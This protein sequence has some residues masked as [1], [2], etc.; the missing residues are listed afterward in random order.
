VPNFRHF[1]GRI[2]RR[3]IALIRRLQQRRRVAAHEQAYRSADALQQ[4][5]TRSPETKL[6]VVLH[7]YYPQMWDYFRTNMTHIA[8]EPFDLYITLPVSE[9]EWRDRLRAQVPGVRIIMV[10]NRGRDILPFIKLAPL[11]SNLGYDYCLKLHTKK[12]LHWDGG[13]E[14]LSEV[15]VSLLPQQ[16]QLMDEII[17]TIKTSAAVIGPRNHYFA[18]PV[19]YPANRGHLMAEISRIVSES[20]AT[21]LDAQPGE[22]GFFGGSMLWLRI[23]A[24]GPILDRNYAVSEFEEEAGQIDGTL[25]H[26][27]ERLLSILPQ[28]GGDKLYSADAAS[29]RPTRLEDAIIPEWSDLYPARADK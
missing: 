22:Y 12:S 21:S 25:A 5:F 9:I 28:L 14:W 24:L 18:L 1:L 26:T 8:V 17:T 7:L 2:K 27:I 3:L 10:P 4:Q 15:M 23:D 19:N 6:A 20:A 13:D 11:L 29:L 16:S